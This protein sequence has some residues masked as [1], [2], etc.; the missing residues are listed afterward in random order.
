VLL[1]FYSFR[2]TARRVLTL[3]S[4]S[5]ITKHEK[6]PE[7]QELFLYL[8][9]EFIGDD[10]GPS[11]TLSHNSFTN[12]KKFTKDS[13]YIFSDRIEANPVFPKVMTEL[14]MKDCMH[15]VE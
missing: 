3:S 9:F 7:V 1:C 8:I 6:A 11:L 15:R 5:T 14:L 12:N 10:R 13:I 2:S 4:S